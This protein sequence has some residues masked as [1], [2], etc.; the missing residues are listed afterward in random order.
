MRISCFQTQRSVDSQPH[1]NRAR[2]IEDPLE[3]VHL[4]EKVSVHA[5]NGSFGEMVLLSIVFA[6]A[7]WAVAPGIDIE[8]SMSHDI[9]NP[10]F[11][12]LVLSFVLEGRF[13]L[14][15][16]S[17][18]CPAGNWDSAIVMSSVRK[19]QPQAVAKGFWELE[20][21]VQ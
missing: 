21:P 15:H 4:R 10:L 3:W 16:V 18:P 17:P 6:E 13:L 11:M 14:I 2:A 1:A 8:Y 12:A 19:L 20:Q 7:D 5:V 9:L